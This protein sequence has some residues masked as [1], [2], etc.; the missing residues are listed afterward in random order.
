VH[1]RA[2]VN[3]F[4][5]GLVALGTTIA[6]ALTPRLW[7]ADRLPLHIALDVTVALV[8]S[9]GALLVLGRLRSGATLDSLPLLTGLLVLAG[10][11]LLYAAIP[12]AISAGAPL[13]IGIWPS[14]VAGVVGATFVAAAGS[15]PPRPLSGGRAWERRALVA[16]I[17]ILVVAAGVGT[18]LRVLLGSGTLPQAWAFNADPFVATTPILV[19]HAVVTGLWAVAAVG[20]ARKA[21]RAGDPFAGWVALACVLLAFSRLQYLLFPSV[22]PHWFYLGDAFRLGGYLLLAVGGVRELAATWH[23]LS[24]TAVLEERRRLARDLHDGLA[25]ELAYISAE[26][27]GELAAAA[28]RALHESRRAI[29]ALTH[30][31]DE[32][33]ARAVAQA[34]EE[35]AQRHGVAIELEL[36]EAAG[37]GADVREE[38]VRIAREAVSNA[39]RH[40]GAGRVRVELAGRDRLVLRVADDGCGF[41][42]DAPQSGHGLVSMQER[43][44]ALGASLSV[45]SGRGRG[46]VVEVALG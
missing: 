21:D 15:L 36:D 9:F 43:A 13:R 34:A 31:I 8:A 35:V 22:Y 44:R 18:L 17:A 33:L 40:A 20:F 46:T 28:Q 12:D 16:A 26:A 11:S 32:P 27:R 42:P 6:V 2:S 7:F 23:R 30:P 5:L 1:T 3:V 45:R 25:Q 37:A 39:A 24:E 41:D 14:L 10:G 4:R 38:L 29:A 19:V